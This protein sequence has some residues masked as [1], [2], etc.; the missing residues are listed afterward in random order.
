MELRIKTSVHPTLPY[1]RRLSSHLPIP[2]DPECGRLWP[3]KD[4][5]IT[6]TRLRCLVKAPY[7]H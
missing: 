1:S 5:A 6:E 2:F 4:L 7:L 3:A